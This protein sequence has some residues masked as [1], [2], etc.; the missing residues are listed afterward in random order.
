MDYPLASHSILASAA[1]AQ[2]SKQT[3]RAQTDVSKVSEVRKTGPELN[4]LVEQVLETVAVVAPDGATFESDLCAEKLYVDADHEF[5][6]EA[7]LRVLEAA[8]AALT[9]L[10][11]EQVLSAKI[12]VRTGSLTDDSGWIYFECAT[13]RLPALDQTRN[14]IC[15]R[16]S[17]AVAHASLVR[18][19]DSAALVL[20]AIGGRIHSRSTDLIDGMTVRLEFKTQEALTKR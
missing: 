2:P 5:V 13:Q 18:G 8:A 19:I 17:T 14:N 16:A 15:W 12:S 9:Q 7:V 11:R 10:P 6:S 3:R 20:E 1:W 4:S